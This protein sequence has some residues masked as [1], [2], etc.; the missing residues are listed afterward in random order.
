MDLN[1]QFLQS[2]AGQTILDRFA[3]LAL[4][5]REFPAAAETVLKMPLGDQQPA[6]LVNDR[7][8][9]LDHLHIPGKIPWEKTPS[10]RKY[11]SA[12]SSRAW[13]GPGA[14]ATAVIGNGEKREIFKKTF[15]CLNR[16][17]L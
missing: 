12:A 2:L 3:L 4:A 9:N 7:A 15:Q 10:D 13:T 11:A 5:S 1:V 16:T 6:V 17:Q 8:A 14:Q